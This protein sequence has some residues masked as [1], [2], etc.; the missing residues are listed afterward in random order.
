MCLNNGTQ[1]FT[2]EALF[3]QLVIEPWR[4]RA[5][6]CLSLHRREFASRLEQRGWTYNPHTHLWSNG[7]EKI[8]TT[9]EPMLFGF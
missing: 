3:N 2:N 9:G 1:S 6:S 7:E 4:R 8:G 5:L